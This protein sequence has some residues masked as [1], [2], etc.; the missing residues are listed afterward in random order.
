MVSLQNASL[1]GL[2]LEV[3]KLFLDN[4]LNEKT[5][6]PKFGPPTH[7]GKIRPKNFIHFVLLLFLGLYVCET[8]RIH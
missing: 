5:I 2:N 6:L 4:L 3:K 1:F 8:T 7:A